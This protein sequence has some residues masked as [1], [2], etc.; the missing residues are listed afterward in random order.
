MSVFASFT[1]SLAAFSGWTTVEGEAAVL[2]A[3]IT[4]CHRVVMCAARPS[5]EHDFRFARG[6]GFER[7]NAV[8][9][10]LPR[11]RLGCQALRDG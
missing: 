11:V 10:I 9:N 5:A 4:E 2:I 6:I 7:S 3:D 1:R 8:A